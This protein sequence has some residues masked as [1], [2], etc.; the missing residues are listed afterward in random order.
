MSRVVAVLRRLLLACAALAL[1]AG[2]PPMPG[3]LATDA[4]VHSGHTGRHGSEPA[5]H[6]QHTSC[7]D[8]C[9]VH[10]GAPFSPVAAS[11]VPAPDVHVVSALPIAL[12]AR[13]V[14]PPR[15]RLP[16]ALAPPSRLG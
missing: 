9:V 10:C 12:V 4:A 1:L 7:C 15:Y 13:L 2:G 6:H 3:S 5:P 11:G 8:L 16:L 14:I